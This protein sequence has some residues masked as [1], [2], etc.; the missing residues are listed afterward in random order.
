[1]ISSIIKGVLQIH[2]NISLNTSLDYKLWPVDKSNEVQTQSP[3][4]SG[5]ESNEVI[6]HMRKKQSDQAHVRIAESHV[7]PV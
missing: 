3:T 7:D 5:T 2:S 1:M 4:S 6:K